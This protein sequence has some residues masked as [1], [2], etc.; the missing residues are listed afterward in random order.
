MFVFGEIACKIACKIAG[1]TI[2]QLNDADW[3]CSHSGNTMNPFLAIFISILM[4]GVGM[5]IILPFIK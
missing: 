2:K 4:S 5:I 3:I 1:G